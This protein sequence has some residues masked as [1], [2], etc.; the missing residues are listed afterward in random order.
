MS[1]VTIGSANIFG[2]KKRHFSILAALVRS[3]VNATK[4]ENIPVRANRNAG[5]NLPTAQ[6]LTALAFS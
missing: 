3:I 2:G 1:T 4:F 6:A 5:P